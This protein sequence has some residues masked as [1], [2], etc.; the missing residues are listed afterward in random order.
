MTTDAPQS[1]DQPP[2]ESAV[3]LPEQPDALLLRSLGLSQEAGTPDGE[4]LPFGADLARQLLAIFDATS[5]GVWV[6]NAEPRL[7]YINRACEQLND[8]RRE[9][10]CG[11]TVASLLGQGNFDSDVTTKV[12]RNRKAMVINQQVK[13]GRALLVQ[14]V[15]VFDEDGKIIYVVGTERDLTELNLLRGQ[16]EESHAT[17]EKMRSELLAL[18]LAELDLE[19]VVAESEEMA[20]VLEV[21]LRAAAFDT[22]VLLNGPTG[23]GK[24]MLARL[25]HQA[26]PR[27]DQPFL[28]L[29]CGALPFNLIEAELFGYEPGAF[30]GAD[31]K[32]KPGLIEAAD[33]G[34]LFLDEINSFPLEL[35]VKLL[36]FLDTQSFIR[37]G[38]RR[39]R[40]VDVRLITATNADLED[41]VTAGEFR[42][43]LHYRL[44]VLPISLPPLHQR[45]SDIPPLVRA[46]LKRM[47]QRHGRDI[48]ISGE[49]LDLLCDYAFPGNVRELQNILERAMVLSNDKAI[50]PQDL[51]PEVR[52]HGSL[53]LLPSS[54]EQ[55]GL[56]EAMDEVERRL[57]SQ[58]QSRCDRQVDIADD[59]KISQASVARLLKK[60][61]LITARSA[62]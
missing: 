1:P 22:T 46:S 57:L 21:T 37:V 42:E 50:A 54:F 11:K 9:E 16:V 35:Q 6:C 3:P 24:S 34:T 41:K 31:P 36:T 18:K 5:D 43:D 61:G 33:G 45:P 17:I 39:P 58:S 28:S 25:I 12:L 38:G 32:G 14:G 48:R 27:K 49:A 7:L 59:L 47:N 13:T 26:S 15:P 52:G 30:T 60:H 8:I 56:K 29:N 4:A 44:A 55:M 23:T 19:D 10:V 20:R 62:S 51:P 40:S 53:P 2:S